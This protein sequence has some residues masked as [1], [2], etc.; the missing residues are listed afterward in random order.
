MKIIYRYG[1]YIVIPDWAE[2]DSWALANDYL[3]TKKK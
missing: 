2:F 1:K 3:L